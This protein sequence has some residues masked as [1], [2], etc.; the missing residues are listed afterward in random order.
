MHGDGSIS[1]VLPCKVHATLLV[2]LFL[3]VVLRSG[4]LVSSR[5][6]IEFSNVF[7]WYVRKPVCWLSGLLPR[8]RIMT[9][10]LACFPCLSVLSIWS[11]GLLVGWLINVIFFPTRSSQHQ[12]CCLLQVLWAGCA[13]VPIDLAHWPKQ[14]CQVVSWVEEKG[15]GWG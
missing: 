4:F 8:L 10:V 7:L 15:E 14:R 13:F 9:R 12:N 3:D 5:V 11:V 6:C 2:H 1:E